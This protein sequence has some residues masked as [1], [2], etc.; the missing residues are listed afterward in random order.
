MRKLIV[1]ALLFSLSALAQPMVMGKSLVLYPGDESTFPSWPDGGTFIAGALRYGTDAGAVYV[2]KYGTRW[3]KMIVLPDLETTGA[4]NLYVDPTGND[5]YACTSSGTLA[6]NT[7]QG[8]VAKIPRIIKHP[9][10]ITLTAGPIGGTSDVILENKIIDTGGSITVTGAFSNANLLTG[11]PNSVVATYTPG[12]VVS[13]VASPIISA[14]A[15]WTTNDLRGYHVVM[16]S[17]AASGQSRVIQSNT[18]NTI[19]LV[20]NFSPAPSINDTFSIQTGSTIN[21]LFK[22]SNIRISNNAIQSEASPLVSFQKLNI[23]AISS[24]NGSSYCLWAI[25]NYDIEFKD[26]R[27]NC[28]GFT[29]AIRSITNSV[30]GAV[31]ISNSSLMTSNT[32]TVGAVN[33]YAGVVSLIDSYI[34]SYATT[35]VAIGSSSTFSMQSVIQKFGTAG[36]ALNINSGSNAVSVSNN[37]YPY[38]ILCDAGATNVSGIG[39][40]GLPYQLAVSTPKIL[41]IVNCGKGISVSTSGTARLISTSGSVLECINTQTCLF[42]SA[43]GSATIGTTGTIYTS[44]VTND[45]SMNS[46]IYS[47]SDFSSLDSISDR[48]GSKVTR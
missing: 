48:Y 8:A 6:C 14:A 21:A 10:T 12:V 13:P 1:F 33:S 47:F 41:S 44:G 7:L 36:L 26:I 22:V 46:V 32:V 30:G 18:T 16:T 15:N 39:V 29:S 35:T 3:D 43:A 2:N 25:D 19:T 4:L 34:S 5:G 45:I 42:L 17:G 9:V 27:L 40:N 37:T 20:A 38:L 11:S 31:S 23:N 24:T 28:A